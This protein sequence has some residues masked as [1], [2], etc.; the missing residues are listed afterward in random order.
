M[1]ID[2]LLTAIVVILLPGTG[3]IYTVSIGLFRG[4]HYSIS[5]AIGCTLGIIPHILAS[6]LGLAALLHTS[7]LAFQ[8]VKYAGAA[9]LLYLA[10]GMWKEK[11]GLQVNQP[12]GEEKGHFSVALQGVLINCLN[13]KLSIFF[14]AFLP[15]F[16]SE[17]AASP[18]GEMALLSATFM[19]LTFVVFLMY[20]IG[21]SWVRHHVIENEKFL[22]WLQRGFAGVFV[23]LGVKLAMEEK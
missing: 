5:A 16:V 9:Y 1:S 4:T 6:I 15:Q 2:F 12:E 19:F 22:T 21:S 14:L 13:P 3:V 8:T 18:L 17:K 11:G 23:A 20:G 10:Y 7:A